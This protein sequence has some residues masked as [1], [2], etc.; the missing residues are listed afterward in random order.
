M[1]FNKSYIGL[2]SDLIKNV[3]GVNQIVLDVGCATG[4][5]GQYLKE[6]KIADKVIGVEIDPNMADEA[7]EKID[8][9]VV[10]NIEDQVTIDA[11]RIA[12]KKFDYILIGDVLEHLV[13]PWQVL[14]K[15]SLLLKEDGRF[16]ISVPNIQHIELFINVYL[17]GE[18][19][20]NDRGMFD[21]THL[22]WFTYKNIQ[23]LADKCNL[24]ILKIDR[25][26][27]FRDSIDSSFP[28]YGRILKKMF[29]SL[30]TFQFVITA[31]KN[32]LH[33]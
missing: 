1:S 33:L 17:R 16:I 15:L 6:N 27:R 20:Y 26:Y 5:N 30:F 22:R 21:K 7:R 9:V 2:R 18:W 32:S 24:K 13:D 23:D 4:T 29:P 25:N 14:N 3:I 28:L 8:L 19:P 12:E 11:I 31:K 10:G